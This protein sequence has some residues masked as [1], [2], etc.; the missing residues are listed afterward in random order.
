MI[1]SQNNYKIHFGKTIKPQYDICR[2]TPRLHRGR[3]SVIPTNHRAN[4][5]NADSCRPRDV[6]S[7]DSSRLS[8]N[9]VDGFLFLYRS[10][11]LSTKHN[12]VRPRK[13]GKTVTLCCVYSR[14]QTFV[15]VTPTLVSFQRTLSIRAPRVNITLI[16]LANRHRFSESPARAWRTI[17]AP[18]LFPHLTDGTL[19]PVRPIE[20]PRARPRTT[21]YQTRVR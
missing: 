16:R 10:N 15:V 18:P 20:D 14:Y 7:K 19:N 1:K 5:V 4:I 11:A 12:H 21:C 17:K 6:V 3:P 8:I 2:T 13:S 9:R